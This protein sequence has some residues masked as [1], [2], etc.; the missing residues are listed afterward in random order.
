MTK[1][2]IA[3][4]GTVLLAVGAFIAWEYQQ[5][6]ALTAERAALREQAAE[7]TSLREENQR[8]TDQ[9]KEAAAKAQADRSE[10]LRWR[11]QGLK[12]PKLEQENA[13]LKLEKSNLTQ[14]AQVPQPTPPVPVAQPVAPAP[15][16]PVAAAPV[17][18]LGLVELIEGTP[19]R[20]DLGA[21]KECVVTAQLLAD[22]NLQLVFTSQSKTAEGAAAQTEYT[23]TVA[24]G[25]Q[26]ASMIDGVE[27]VLTPSL[28]P[29]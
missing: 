25:S 26:M 28:K 29:K 15:Q 16:Q 22:G 14:V 10:L 6:A 11:A 1:L 23:A 4:L 12:L 3:A 21:G 17:A 8:L 13:R 27:V 5:I 19:T 7:A 20:L 9:L 24:P 18:D 2:N